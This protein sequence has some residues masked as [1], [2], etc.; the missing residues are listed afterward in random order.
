MIPQDTLKRWLLPVAGIL[1]TAGLASLLSKGELVLTLISVSSALLLGLLYILLFFHFPKLTI[2]IVLTIS[3][4]LSVGAIYFFDKNSKISPATKT[5]TLYDLNDWEKK[6]WKGPDH[7]G[8]NLTRTPTLDAEVRSEN[9]QW[10]RLVPA[11]QHESNGRTLRLALT[12]KISNADQLKP[13]L[14]LFSR[15]WTQKSVNGYTEY[16]TIVDPVTYGRPC[17]VNESF[18]FERAQPGTYEI[19]YRIVGTDNNELEVRPKDTT[20]KLILK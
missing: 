14:T 17:R 18:G 6:I 15:E 9:Q 8:I 13:R 19:I 20:V 2:W 11:V 5:I 12:I 4:L 10:Y 7:E 16:T 1:G 3:G